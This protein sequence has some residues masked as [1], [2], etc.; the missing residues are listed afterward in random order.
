[1]SVYLWIAG[2]FLVLA[3]F[4]AVCWFL[5]KGAAVMWRVATQPHKQGRRVSGA[6]SAIINSWWAE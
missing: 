4:T 1:V 2:T 3:A 6:K 5:L